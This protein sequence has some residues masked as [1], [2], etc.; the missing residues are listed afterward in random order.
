MTVCPLKRV[1]R[2]LDVLGNAVLL[3]GTGQAMNYEGGF[4]GEIC[5]P[6]CPSLLYIR[7][8]IVDTLTANV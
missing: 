2:L 3:P 4:H 1:C 8:N 5:A 6:S 7:R